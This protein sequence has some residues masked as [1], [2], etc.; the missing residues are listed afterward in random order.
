MLTSREI[1]RSV[2]LYDVT[3]LEAGRAPDLRDKETEAIPGTR[4]RIPLRLCV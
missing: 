2:A 3:T 1:G 4:H